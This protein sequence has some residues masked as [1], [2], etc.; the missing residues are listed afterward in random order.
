M[1][2]KPSTQDALALAQS[3]VQGQTTAQAALQASLQAVARL[4]PQVN[5]IDTQAP[6]AAL[7]RAQALD[8]ELAALRTD[9][10]R[11]ALLEERPFFGVPLPLKDLG[12]ACV[13]LP[14][15]M[16]SA[17]FR[18]TSFDLD[19]ELVRRYPA[20][21]FVPL[22]PTNYP[23]PG[24]RPTPVSTVY[25]GSL[26]TPAHLPPPAPR[27]GCPSARGRASGRGSLVA[28]RPVRVA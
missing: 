26:L 16:G 24:V 11:A 17:F 20:A 23:D 6:E 15:S 9:S 4:N 27:T 28:L 13:D 14:S 19:G 1:T 8:A 18:L 2:M 3:I 10:Q 25:R 5:A 12:L 7:R 21:G 22:P